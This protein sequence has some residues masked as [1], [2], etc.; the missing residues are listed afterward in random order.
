MAAASYG[1]CRVAFAVLGR[2]VEGQAVNGYY[3]RNSDGWLVHFTDLNDAAGTAICAVPAGGYN[4]A[5]EIGSTGMDAST[6]KATGMSWSNTT[7]TMWAS[8]TSLS[9]TDMVYEGTLD[10]ATGHFTQLVSASA[11]V[12]MDIA[13]DAVPPGAGESGSCMWHLSGY[14]MLFWWKTGTDWTVN[15][16]VGS[17]LCSQYDSDA[18]GG[19]S[20]DPTTGKLLAIGV[21]AYGGEMMAE[22][23]TDSG[24]L[25]AYPV[26]DR[27][28]A[29][30]LSFGPI[31]TTKT[32]SAECVAR[33]HYE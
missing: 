5:V 23:Y 15:M 14:G 8:F 11:L 19:L 4:A 25:S 17:Y 6:K 27:S 33:P 22:I 7:S 9:S 18:V 12:V 30:C 13:W 29:A 16:M 1:L 24:C 31:V 3:I 32:Y 21:G 20:R 28:D 2:G 26:I 10:L